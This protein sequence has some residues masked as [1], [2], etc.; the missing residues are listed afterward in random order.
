MKPALVRGKLAL[1]VFP[2]FRS[3]LAMENRKS[4]PKKKDTAENTATP[5]PS[6]ENEEDFLNNYKDDSKYGG[7]PLDA[8]VK[9]IQ[10][11]LFP[12]GNF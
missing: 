9:T 6:N 1:A 2:W 7:T 10:V 5:L 3:S 8:P 11:P 4:S 12:C